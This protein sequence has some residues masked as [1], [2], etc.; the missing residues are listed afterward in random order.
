MGDSPDLRSLARSHR[1]SGVPEVDYEDYDA[2][3][4]LHWGGPAPKWFPEAMAAYPE[5]FANQRGKVALITG[6]TSGIGLYAA[7]AL[8]SSCRSGRASHTRRR[9]RCAPSRPMCL[10]RLCWCL[11]S[12]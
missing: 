2:S 9:V 12:R 11:L 6:G 5:R 8:H 7:W 1:D 4:R 10:V 3:S